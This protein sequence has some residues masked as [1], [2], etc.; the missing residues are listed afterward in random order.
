MDNL[1]AVNHFSPPPLALFVCLS[2]GPPHPLVHLPSP[3]RQLHQLYNSSVTEV[4]EGLQNLEQCPGQ[5]FQV[6]LLHT[7]LL[8]A[9]A[10]TSDV[11]LQP[12]LSSWD[13]LVK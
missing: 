1:N 9:P 8:A 5:T 12:Y 6:V 4:A 2:W 13:E 3:H 10:S 7:H 11:L